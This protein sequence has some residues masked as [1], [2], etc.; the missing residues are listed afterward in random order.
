MQFSV[1]AFNGL[2]RSMGQSV[3]WRRSSLCPC[4]DPYSGAAQ[5]GCQH[6][7]GLGWSWASPVPAWT[8]LASQRVAKEWAAFGLWESGDVVLSVPSDSPL[9]AAGENDRVLM[10]NSSEPFSIH[11]TRD[12]D[13]RFRFPVVQIDRV[14]WINP[15]SSALVEGG[16]PTVGADGAPAWTDPAGAPEP[17]VQYA[18]TGRKRPEY[19]LFRDLPQ[20]RAHFG[21]MA[22]PRR[23]VLRRFDLFGSQSGSYPS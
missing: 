3:A 2:L 14:A 1:S 12:G 15:G 11:M 18:V 6:C 13:E 7:A 19:Y 22:L 21:G 8:G 23:M 5:Q 16:I 10:L 17:G 20:D 9:Y 4:R